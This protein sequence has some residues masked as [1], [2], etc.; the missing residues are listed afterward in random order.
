MPITC[1]NLSLVVVALVAGLLSVGCATSERLSP[2]TFFVTSSGP[3]KGGDLGG[4]AGADARCQSLAAS[5]GAGARR[6]HAYLSIQPTA[7]APGINAR[8]RIGIGPWQNATGVVIADNLEQLHTANRIS[9]ATALTETGAVVSGRGDTRNLHDMLTGSQP[10]GTFILGAVN[11]TCSNWTQS[12]RGAAMVGHHD[13][14]GLDESAPA[15]SWNSSHPS[16]GCS[17]EALATTGG[18]GLFYC[19]SVN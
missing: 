19:F 3:G 9:K 7:A 12:Q 17:P 10:D 4:L 5:A 15:K 11:S 18:G 6:W 13:R 16:R 14:I 8:D 2:M 1:R